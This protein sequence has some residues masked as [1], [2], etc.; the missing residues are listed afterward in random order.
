MP[1]LDDFREMID[2]VDDASVLESGQTLLREM[3][4]INEMKI[5]LEQL[6]SELTNGGKAIFYFFAEEL[7]EDEIVFAAERISGRIKRLKRSEDL[8][9]KEKEDSTIEEK[10]DE[11]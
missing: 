7:N 1:R 4:Q 9:N 5:K 3:I 11:E 10:S 6:E 2:G 8:K